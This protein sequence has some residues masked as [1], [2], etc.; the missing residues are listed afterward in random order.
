MFLEIYF[1]FLGLYIAKKWRWRRRL[2]KVVNL[3]TVDGDPAAF[4]EQIEPFYRNAKGP[5]M[6]SLLTLN[7]AAGLSYLGDWEQAYE[8]HQS[9]D[10]VDAKQHPELEMLYVNNTL[11]TLLLL[12]RFPEA[13]EFFLTHEKRLYP[14]SKNR[15]INLAAMGTLATYRYFFHSPTEAQNLYVR[16][17]ESDRPRISQASNH[18]F[19]GRILLA[20]GRQDE[21]FTHLES[22]VE[23]GP[24]TYLPEEVRALAQ[25]RERIG[26]PGAGTQA[27]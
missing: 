20:A 12:G 4:L 14:E 2:Q 3:L 17:L 26:P 18:Y 9:V 7:K 23:L 15:E 24:K 5:L 19:L 11:Y 13:R 25:G 6:R 27:Q 1:T 21:A 22:A 10:F 16:L 8:L